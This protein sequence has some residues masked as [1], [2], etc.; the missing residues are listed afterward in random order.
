M[1]DKI[2]YWINQDGEQTGPLT[3]DQLELMTLS[4]KSYV[5]SAGFD[6]WKPIGE[7]EDLSHL[8]P[9]SSAIPPLPIEPAVNEPLEQPAAEPM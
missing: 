1:S 9:T 7:V 8:L 3:I 2:Q 6:D 4:E 5:W